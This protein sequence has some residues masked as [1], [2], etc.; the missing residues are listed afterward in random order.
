M[1]RMTCIARSVCLD[2]F[3][4]AEETDGLEQTIQSPYPGVKVASCIGSLTAWMQNTAARSGSRWVTQ[5][6]V[7]KIEERKRWML[8]PSE[9]RTYYEQLPRI[10][11]YAEHFNSP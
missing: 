6:M 2:C 10:I 9:N 4:I 3:W 1:S 7:I 8:M 11:S 5:R